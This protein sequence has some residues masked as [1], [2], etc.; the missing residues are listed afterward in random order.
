MLRTKKMIHQLRTLKSGVLE[1]PLVEVLREVREGKKILAECV[2]NEIWRTEG[3]QRCVVV[4]RDILSE[5]QWVCYR[6]S[7]ASC[8]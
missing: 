7:F 5:T 4:Y 6:L 8:P 3:I 2:H 1:D